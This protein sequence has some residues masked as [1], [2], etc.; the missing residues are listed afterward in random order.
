M[1][2]PLLDGA[3][4]G[5]RRRGRE[6]LRADTLERRRDAVV[7][8]AD[9]Q[10]E[11]EIEIEVEV[12]VEVRIEVQVDVARIRVLLV[13]VKWCFRDQHYLLGLLDEVR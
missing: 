7:A 9:T 5:R 13:V 4:N 1:L 3:W 6:V 2:L 8:V 11:I 12:E 10:V